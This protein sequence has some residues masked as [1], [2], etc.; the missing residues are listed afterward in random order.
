LRGPGRAENGRPRLLLVFPQKK[1]FYGFAPPLGLAYIAAATPGHW[2]VEILDESSGPG[3]Y[4]KRKPDL[5]GISAMTVQATRAYRIAAHFKTRGI[6]VVMGGIHPSMCPDE[7]LAHVDTVVS[8]EGEEIWPRVIGD[9]EAGRMAR[10]YRAETPVDL[11]RLVRPRR[12]LF[13][14]RRLVDVLQTARGCPFDCSF[15]AVSTF[16]GRLF[17]LRPVDDVLDEIR[18]LPKRIVMFNDDNLIGSG[19]AHRERA[20]ALFEGMIRSGTRKRWVSQASVN[21]ADD[22]RILRLMKASGCAGLLIGFESLDP[23]TLNRMGKAA[24]LKRGEPALFYREVIRK[25]HRHGIAVLGFLI[26]D[27]AEGRE[28]ILRQIAFI[29][30][31]GVDLINYPVLTPF[32]GTRLYAEKKDSIFYNHYPS[33]WDA[34]DRGRLVFPS[35]LPPAEFYALREWMTRDANSVRRAMERGW[36]CL[37]YSKSP[38]FASAVL[39]LNLVQTRLPRNDVRIYREEMRRLS[40]RPNPGPSPDCIPP[41]SR[42]N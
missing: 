1:T 37:V 25:L 30:S 18:S 38:G 11:E 5:V 19:P 16:N 4:L 32:P 26:T 22:E 29:R 39:A 34:Y 14:R 3:D 15:C 8:G 7:A 6:P 31:S 2:D 24:N 20:A 23:E 13:P 17:R 10:F 42:L 9:F 35:R 36:R 12:D 27:P 41:G 21:V 40:A 33:D 28:A